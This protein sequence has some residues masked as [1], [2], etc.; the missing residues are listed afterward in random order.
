MRVAEYIIAL[1]G[2]LIVLFL[3]LFLSKQTLPVFDYD[4]SWN[5]ITL[6]HPHQA[7]AKGADP[8]ARFD[9]EVVG[10]LLPDSSNLLV[11]LRPYFHGASGEPAEFKSAPLLTVPGEGL[12][13]RRE[14]VNQGV[15]KEFEYYLSLTAIKDSTGADTTLA[16]IPRQYLTDQKSTLKVRFE[17][18]PNTPVLII[19]IALMYCA[20]FAA[21]LAVFAGFDDR[22]GINRSRRIGRSTLAIVIFLIVS[23][24]VLGP[25]IERQTYGTFWSGIPISTNL[26][27]TFSLL[28]CLF[29]LGML[30]L[31]KGSS[32]AGKSEKDLVALPAAR[33]LAIV[34][35]IAMIIVYLIPHG[36]GRT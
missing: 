26:T 25:V 29:W 5:D 14:L 9:V 19:H 24:F 1:G 8:S 4:T 6:R 30:I 33:A 17:G 15:G 3:S 11:Y 13:Y 20:L 12:L 35:L 28:L 21:F 22:P 36:T 34:G 27:D 32:L 16:T 23:V 31:L 7:L 18:K 2:T 10:G